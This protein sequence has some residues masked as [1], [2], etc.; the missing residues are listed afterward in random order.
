MLSARLL[1]LYPDS[2]LVGIDL[3]EG[4]LARC[5]A[6]WEGDRRVRFVLGDAE[7]PEMRVPAAGLVASSCAL[8]WFADLPATVAMW[9]GT[10]V[11]GGVMALAALVEGSFAELDSAHAEA[12]GA[13]LPGLDF[14]SPM[15]LVAIA[16]DA[17][18]TVRAAEAETREVR[19]GDAREALRAFRKIG[20]A[21]S[22]QPGRAPL[23]P[24][25]MRRLLAA[26]DRRCDGLGRM[27]MTYRALHLVAE[28]PS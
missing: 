13:R 11:P 18:L 19:H 6:R 5:R 24:A 20:A 4:M 17:G 8:Q 3:A 7:D 28:K 12:L 9:A 2:E 15:R 10:L 27:P 26:C 16:R 14:P 25:A 22:G 1:S 23:P 21:L